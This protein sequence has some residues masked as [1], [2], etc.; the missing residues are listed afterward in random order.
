MIINMLP[1]GL[2]D[3]ISFTPLVREMRRILP[4]EKITIKGSKF[5]VWENNPHL[6]GGEVESGLN[7]VIDFSGRTL[8]TESTLAGFFAEQMGVSLVDNLPEI[9]L[10]QEELNQDFG[11]TDWKRTVAIDVWSSAKYRRWPAIK[12]AQVA[13]D[14]TSMGWRV[15]EVGKHEEAIPCWKSF[16]NKLTVRQV[17]SL[18]RRCSLF[19]GNDSGLTHLSAAMGTPQVALYGWIHPAERAYWNTVPVRSDRVCHIAC[20]GRRACTV[21]EEPIGCRPYLNEEAPSWRFTGIP[22]ERVLE[23]VEVAVRRHKIQ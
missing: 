19:I 1:F 5:P 15:V 13:Q 21:Q 20:L 8:Q 14:L 23:A 3:E 10:T 12:F 6:L 11:V 9:F 4:N 18:L 16:R 7:F 17:A 22:V 2:G